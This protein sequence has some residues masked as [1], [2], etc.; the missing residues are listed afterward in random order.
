VQQEDSFY[1]TRVDGFGQDNY[2]NSE[3]AEIYFP[4]TGSLEI[5]AMDIEVDQDK[6]IA[7]WRDDFLD[8]GTLLMGDVINVDLGGQWRSTLEWSSDE[9]VTKTGWT[10]VWKPSQ[11]PTLTIPENTAAPANAAGLIIAPIYNDFAEFDNTI[12]GGA[13]AIEGNSASQTYVSATDFVGGTATTA[14]TGQCTP[15]IINCPVPIQWSNF[16]YTTPGNNDRRSPDATKIGACTKQPSVNGQDPF[17]LVEKTTCGATRQFDANRGM[18]IDNLTLT[19]LQSDIDQLMSVYQTEVLN[20]AGG[21]YFVKTETF[22]APVLPPTITCVCEAGW[23][24]DSVYS[25]SGV[26]PAPPPPVQTSKIAKNATANVVASLRIYKDPT[27]SV[28]VNPLENLPNSVER[29]W[30]EVTTQFLGNR[31]QMRDCTAARS[32]AELSSPDRSLP[33]MQNFCTTQLFDV[34]VHPLPYGVTHMARIS[35]DR[36][37]FRDGGSVYIRCKIRACAQLPC[38]SCG[39]RRELREGESEHEV[40]FRPGDQDWPELRR[41]K[42]T[43][44]THATLGGDE[45]EGDSVSN[46]VKVSPKNAKV[47]VGNSTMVREPWMVESTAKKALELAPPIEAKQVW[48]ATTT[49]VTA[50]HMGAITSKLQIKG[51]TEVWAMQ[52]RVAIEKAL[53]TAL[54]LPPTE[55]VAVQKIRKLTIMKGAIGGVTRTANS[56]RRLLTE[57]FEVLDAPKKVDYL[58]S[59]KLD[60][61]L[62]QRFGGKRFFTSAKHAV[63]TKALQRVSE[64]RRARSLLQEERRRGLQSQVQRTE[65]RVQIDFLVRVSDI[66]KI[67]P[68]ST[69]LQLLAAGAPMTTQVFLSSLDEVL[70]AGGESAAKIAF[71]DVAFQEPRTYATN[72]A[73]DVIEGK[74]PWPTT[75]APGAT[76]LMG[77]P[78]GVPLAGA[79]GPISVSVTV[80]DTKTTDET[81][82]GG[83]GDM[84]LILVVVG[85]GTLIL[86]LFAIVIFMFCYTANIAQRSGPVVSPAQVADGKISIKEHGNTVISMDSGAMNVDDVAKFIKPDSGYKSKVGPKAGQL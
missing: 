82:G 25:V 77:V 4:T 50:K 45:M 40:T 14:A 49:G 85:A 27:F 61:A 71:P 5:A 20:N 10:L 74:L 21:F 38:G 37:A 66:R 80:G 64:A 9:T 18:I 31:V 26:T 52:N 63:C 79:G 15:S 47:L 41:L 39:Q 86:V 76:P 33:I 23:E 59:D 22:I 68:T 42:E 69:K 1:I 19:V 58:S 35:T 32:E 56:T 28:L 75:P 43:S 55:E 16:N 57:D 8:L 34:Q 81:E 83:G 72:Y 67:M 65:E 11:L 78:M 62:L 46:Y 70:V 12:H 17:F 30:L 3:A 29:Y 51:F 2:E 53:H 60:A 44:A 48:A 13:M 6:L 36:F 24:A 73:A 54:E 84:T 7:N